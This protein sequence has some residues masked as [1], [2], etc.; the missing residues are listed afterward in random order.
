MRLVMTTLCRSCFTWNTRWSQRILPVLL[1]NMPCQCL[2]AYLYV[3]QL[4]RA[5][6]AWEYLRRNPTYRRCWNEEVA[7]GCQAARQWGLL[8][9]EDP[10]LD[11]RHAQPL[12]TEPSADTVWLSRASEGH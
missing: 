7:S 8:A 1:S 2:A 10:D 12:W 3:L 4:D 5:A 11:A 6:L 9:L